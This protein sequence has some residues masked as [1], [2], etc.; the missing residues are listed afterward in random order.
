MLG[1]KSQFLFKGIPYK[2]ISYCTNSRYI[3]LETIGDF[4]MIFGQKWLYKNVNVG[5]K[6]RKIF[7][8][9]T[10]LQFLLSYFCT[11]S[12][13]INFINYLR[14]RSIYP[15]FWS[16]F[17]ISNYLEKLWFYSCLQIYSNFWLMFLLVNYLEKSYNFL[18]H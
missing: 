10:C 16:M 8:S 6:K 5:N 11:V 13:C 17:I 7:Y 15:N 18:F 14:Y 9:K 3:K 4:V 2:R 1:I 12:F